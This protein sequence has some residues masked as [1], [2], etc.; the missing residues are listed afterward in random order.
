MPWTNPMVVRAWIKLEPYIAYESRR[1]REPDYYKGVRRLA[2]RCLA[3]RAEQLP[4]A[5]ITWLDG[6]L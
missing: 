5:E 3:W 1:R 4:G 2:E 6:A